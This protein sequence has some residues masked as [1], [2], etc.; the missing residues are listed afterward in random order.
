[1][2]A[3]NPNP[4]AFYFISNYFLAIGNFGWKYYITILGEEN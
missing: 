2:A 4:F 3:I 1:V